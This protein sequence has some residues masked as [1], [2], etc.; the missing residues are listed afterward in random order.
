MSASDPAQLPRLLAG[1]TFSRS[2]DLVAHE[3]IHGQ[4]PVPVMPAAAS[5]R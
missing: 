2:L 3:A 4:L 1:C 5:T